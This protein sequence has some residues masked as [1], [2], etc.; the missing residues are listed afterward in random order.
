[1]G[2]FNKLMADYF[3][4]CIFEA[5][6]TGKCGPTL[7]SRVCETKPDC[8]PDHCVPSSAHPISSLQE[9]SAL[10]DHG[11][12]P[13]YHLSVRP[14]TNEQLLHFGPTTTRRQYAPVT[15]HEN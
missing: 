3:A 14:I 8:S 13:Y 15:S 2:Y 7:T 5:C 6:A 4:M 1:M 10:P 11:P 9:L 12:P